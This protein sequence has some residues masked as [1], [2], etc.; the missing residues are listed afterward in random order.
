AVEAARQLYRLPY[1]LARFNAVERNEWIDYECARA[2]EPSRVF[3]GRY[4]PAGAVF[5]ATPGS[6]E[7]FLTERYCLYSVD[8]SGALHRA[9]IHHAPWPLQPAEAEID[10]TTLSPLPVDGAPLC[11]YARRLDVVVWPLEHVR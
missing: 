2:S 6:L 10:L 3:S 5:T 4:R 1:F 8:G 11:H 7:W 9:E